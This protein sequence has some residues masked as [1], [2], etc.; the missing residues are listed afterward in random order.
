MISLASVSLSPHG[1]FQTP[2][3]GAWNMYVHYLSVFFQRFISHSPSGSTNAFTSQ[4][5]SS[6]G[7]SSSMNDSNGST[8][9]L[10]TRWLPVFWQA[11][12]MLVCDFLP[13][14]LQLRFAQGGIIGITV[15]DPNPLIS[16]QNGQG[17]ISE[18]GVV[19]VFQLIAM[20]S[21]CFSAAIEVCRR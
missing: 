9:N 4:L 18:V 7:S 6:I 16:W 13:T 21:F 19:P 14:V 3:N 2:M 20:C 17:R 8:P 15:R 1:F 10:P 12:G 11:A 5:R